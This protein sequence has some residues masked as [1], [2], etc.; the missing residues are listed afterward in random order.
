MKLVVASVAVLEAIER[1]LAAVK[2][3]DRT[4]MDKEPPAFNRAITSIGMTAI[5][6]GK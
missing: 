6:A 2:V 4:L 3:E 5:T 1:E